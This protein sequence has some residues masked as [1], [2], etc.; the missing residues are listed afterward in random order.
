MLTENGPLVVLAVAIALLVGIVAP[1][2]A[3]F[4]NFGGFGSAAPRSNARQRRR[5]RLVRRRFLRAVPA[6]AAQARD[7]GFLQGAGAGQARPQFRAG[8]Q[9]AGARRRHGRLA[10]LRPRGRLHR[11]AR[12]GRDPQAPT[13]VRPDQISAEG[14]AVRLGGGGQGHSRHRKARRHRRHARPQRPHRDARAGGGK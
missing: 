8:A 9:R 3:Q 11:A 7:A 14:R 2:S 13:V 4:F 5:R 12:H 6:A 1:A 10:R